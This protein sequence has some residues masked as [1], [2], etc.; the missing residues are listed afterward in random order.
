MGQKQSTR[1]MLKPGDHIF[2]NRAGDLYYH[3]GIYV[4]DDLVIH[5]M[6]AGIKKKNSKCGSCTKCGYNGR[7]NGVVKTC[8]DCFLDGKNLYIFEYGIPCKSPD[9]V[10]KIATE[11]LQ[12]E[13][14]FGTY[15]FVS[16][17]CEDFASYCKTGQR[18]C[19]QRESFIRVVTRLI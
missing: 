15:N 17:N 2:T 10:I 18:L 11:F 13:R 1:S 19:S 5:L 7:G 14:D 6:A 8:L 12:G 3:H 9:E 16:N 4:G